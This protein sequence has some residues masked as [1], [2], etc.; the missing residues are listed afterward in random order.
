MQYTHP[1]M[2]SAQWLVDLVRQ[3]EYIQ[4]YEQY[5]AEHARGVEN[6]SYDW[7]DPVTVW[8]DALITKAKKREW[9]RKTLSLEV[10]DPSV[11]NDNQCIVLMKIVTQTENGD[12]RE[13]QEYVLYTREN[14]KVIEE[15]FFYIMPEYTWSED[16]ILARNFFQ[17]LQQPDFR[18]LYKNYFATDASS[19][20][21]RWD[22]TIPAITTWVEN[23]ITKWEQW[24]KWKEMIEGYTK[25]L[26]IVHDWQFIVSMGVTTKDMSSWKQESMNEF[27]LY[28][29]TE[30]KI[31]EERFFYISL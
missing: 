15:R 17:D 16:D 31:S 26:S 30:G 29:I 9:M 1:L 21:A 22:E 19:V 20:E 8:R 18:A 27:V 23:M 6:F 10:S 4:A 13:D 5:F 11:F 14:E 28:T 7:S 12:T 2:Q 25:N 3:G 24:E